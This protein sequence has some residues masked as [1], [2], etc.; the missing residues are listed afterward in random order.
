[1]DRYKTCFLALL[2]AVN[3]H[4]SGRE[5]SLF[6]EGVESLSLEQLEDRLKSVDFELEHL[7]RYSMRSEIGSVGYRSHLSTTPDVTNEWIQINLGQKTAIDQIVLVPSIRRDARSGFKADG[8]PLAFRI[9]AGD[10][11]ETNVV[12]SFDAT[13]HLLPRIAPLVV[14]CSS[15]TASWVRVEASCLTPRSF[16]GKYNLEFSEIMVFQGEENVALRRNV[17][18]SSVNESEYGSRKRK[19]LVDGFVPYLM[20][21]AQGDQ[22]IAF[23]SEIGIGDRP[24]LTI[25]LGAIEPLNRIHLHPVDMTDTVPQSTPSDFGIP[26]QFIVEGATQSDFSDAVRLIEWQLQSIYEV[27]P[28]IMRRFPE[29]PCRYVRLTALEPYIDTGRQGSGSRIGFAEIELFAR[30]R[31]VAL[32]KPVHANFE[33]KSPSRSFSALT[34]GHN[35]YGEI[36]PVRE[37]LNELARRNDLETMRPSITAALNRRYA[38]QKIRLNRMYWL[39]ALLAAGI[40]LTVLVE[41]LVHLKH[42]ARIRERYAADLHDELGANIHTI[43]LLGDV[44][45]SS[46]DKPDR[47]KSTLMNSRDLTE[48]TGVAVRHCIT[49]QEVNGLNG[50]LKNDVERVSQRILADF[51]YDVSIT[52]EEFLKKLNPRKRNDV[53]LFYK[54]CLVNI[55]RHSAATRVKTTLAAT[56]KQIVLTICDN[57][58][59]IANDEKNN[60][61]KSLKRRAR[62]MHAQVQVDS[63]TGEGT[64]VTLKLR[65]RF[66]L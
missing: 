62:L 7:A 19:F 10:S 29:T 64:C 63:S 6:V 1:M 22:S 43:G 44:A 40:V 34:D 61:P 11:Q 35:L 66:W 33:L 56:R 39:A 60:V 37:W 55:S 17:Q 50:S 46:L 20:D 23:V 26:P 5:L 30:G 65:T 59:G 21:A 9:V 13:D 41:R 24:E 8:F 4:V 27:G 57:G 16:D 58:R 36:L 32:E 31:N 38:W 53:F 54:E 28:I 25:D 12:A 15:V 49:M 51:E 52:G 3:C 42:L 48:R 45:L 47:L 2:L 18:A 14:N